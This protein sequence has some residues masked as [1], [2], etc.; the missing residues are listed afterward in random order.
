MHISFLFCQGCFKNGS[1]HI[2]KSCDLEI[3][4]DLFKTDAIVQST[5]Q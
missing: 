3:I 2:L 5:L 1:Q 4:I